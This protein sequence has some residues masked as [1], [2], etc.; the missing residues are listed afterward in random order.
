M[1][2]NGLTQGN[3]IVRVQSQGRS[4]VTRMQVR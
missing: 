4:A 3:Y 1:K 2:F